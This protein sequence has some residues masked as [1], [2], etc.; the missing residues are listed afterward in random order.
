[1]LFP[2]PWR[3]WSLPRHVG[4]RRT[5][6]DLYTSG[7]GQGG[8]HRDLFGCPCFVLGALLSA[9]LFALHV[10]NPACVSP[11]CVPYMLL[12]LPLGPLMSTSPSSVSCSFSLFEACFGYRGW[13]FCFPPAHVCRLLTTA[14]LVPVRVTPLS[15]GPGV[16]GSDGVRRRRASLV[17]LD[18]TGH[19]LLR[20]ICMKGVGN[21]ALRGLC[22]SKKTNPGS[23]HSGDI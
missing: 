18:V 17:L 1:M 21:Q 5:L 13:S 8:L 12:S 15:D 3:Y 10:M 4:R 20:L 9:C 19:F 11:Q 22:S 2:V 6:G 7:W 16:G 14:A 23:L